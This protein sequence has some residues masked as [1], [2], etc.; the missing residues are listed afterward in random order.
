VIAVFAVVGAAYAGLLPFP[1]G[2]EQA[3]A[4]EEQTAGGGQQ[5]AAGSGQTA[6]GGEPQ[7]AGTEQAASGE[8]Q[9]PTANNEQTADGSGQP[10]ADNGQAA[11]GSTG[12]LVIRVADITEDATFIPYKGPDYEMEIIAVKASDGTIRTAFN[13]C[14][15]CYSS[16]RGYYKQEGDLLV[17]Q[18]C[19]NTFGMDDVEVTK[20][21]CNP[22]PITSEYKAETADTITITGEFLEAAQVIFENWKL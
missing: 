1:G 18:N 5:A 3:A 10:A 17:C 4:G 19:G 7:S 15:V 8:E 14:Q 22:F 13:T 9:Q 2:G 21:G 11:A 20:G 12:D 16:G 6:S